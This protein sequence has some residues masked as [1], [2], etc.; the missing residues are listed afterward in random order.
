MNGKSTHVDSVR[1]GTVSVKS[2]IDNRIRGI[3]T[4]KC[5]VL[6]ITENKEASTRYECLILK[7]SFKQGNGHAAYP[8]LMMVINLGND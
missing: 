5:R 6:G 8:L 3:Q 2:Q 1:E 4:L 7:S